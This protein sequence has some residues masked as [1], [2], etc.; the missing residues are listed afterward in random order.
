MPLILDDADCLLWII[1]PSISPFV[2]NKNKRRNILSE[3]ALKNPRSLLN[4]IK[5]RCFYN[6]SLRQEIVDNIK[7]YQSNDTLRLYTFNDK[8][9]GNIEYIDEPFSIDECQQWLSNNL[10]NPRTNEKINI[11]SHVFIELIYTTIQY[12]LPIPPISYTPPISKFE[13]LVYNRMNKIIKDVKFRFE[14]MKEND[15]LFL[16]HDVAS[17]DRKLQVET[18][19]SAA[20]KATNSFDVSSSPV[21]YKSLNMSQKIRLRDKKLENKEEEKLVTEHLY[22]KGFVIKQKKDKKVDKEEDKDVFDNFR[23]F[24]IDLQDEGLNND[25]LINYILEDV[26]DHYKISI[27]E[28]IKKFIT[29]PPPNFIPQSFLVKNH[30]DKIEGV[31]RKF[32]NNICAQL[33][34]PAL[35]FDRYIEISVLSYNNLYK[36]FRNNELIDNVIGELNVFVDRYSSVLDDKVI[37]Y[38]KNLVEDIIPGNLISTVNINVLSRISYNT[39]ISNYQNY[40]YTF[41]CKYNIKEVKHL[42]LRLPEGMGLLIGKPLI[43]AFSNERYFNSNPDY[44]VI[45]EDNRL[46]HF[47]YEECKNWVMIPIINP[48]T[49][50]PILIDTPTYNTLLVISYQYDTNLIPRMITS[51]G[52]KILIALRD[53]IH[54]ILE[55]KGQPPQSREQLENYLIKKKI[56]SDEEFKRANELKELASKYTQ[57][58]NIAGLKWKNVG[59]KKP[60]T[61]IEIIDKKLKAAF[62]KLTDKDGEPPFYVLFSEEDFAK[63]GITDI[64]KDSYI[65]IATYYIPAIDTRKSYTNTVG[66]RWRKINDERYKQGIKRKGV[67]II[68]KKLSKAFSKSI[69][70]D[71]RLPGKVL[72]SMKDF[73]NFGI[74][75]VAKNRYVKLAYYYKPVFAK[76]ANSASRVSSASNSL[77]ATPK[78]NIVRTADYIAKNRYNI[79]NCLKWVMQPNKDPITNELIYT[80]SPE[81]N[82]IFEQALIFDNHIEP[83]DITPKGIKFKNRLLKVQKTLIGISKFKKKTPYDVS[84]AERYE[85]LTKSEICDSINNIHVDDDKDTKYSYFKNKMLKMCDKYLGEKR[86]CNLANIKKKINDK[87]IKG[88]R[89]VVTAFSYYEGSALCSLIVDYDIR[90]K[91]LKLYDNDV[92]NKFINHYKRIF[93]VLIY[94]IVEQYGNLHSIK[95]R[96]VDVG[97]VSREFFTKLFEELFCD[98]ENKKRP[99]IQPEKNNGSNRY[100][101]NPNFEPDENFKTVIKYINKDIKVIGDYNT[102]E[103]YEHIYYIIGKF[104]GITLVNEEIGLPKQFSTYILSRFINPQKTINYYDILYYYLKDFSNSRP[105]MNMMN[106]KQKNNIDYC[107]FNFNDY[108]IISKSLKSNPEG[109]PITKENY[110]KYIL[111]LAK[112]IVTKNFLLKK[113]EGYDKNMKKRYE[114]LFSGFNSELS[115]ILYNNNV[116]IDMLDKLITNEQLDPV[117]LIEFAKKLKI[118]VIKFVGQE[119]IYN[120]NTYPTKTDEEIHSIIKEL[121]IYL[122]NIITIKR[123]GTTDEQHYGFIKK[124]LQFWSGFSHY[125]KLAGVEENGYKFFYLYGGDVRMFPMAHTC[126]YQL[127]FFGF[128]EDKTTAEEKE[129]YLYDKLKFAVFSAGGM[130]IA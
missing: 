123:E 55:E 98:E 95:K 124:L 26:E 100:Y 7:E 120:P 85:I 20:A 22:K 90:N 79:I 10:V 63:F 33:I 44:R 9:A 105:Y 52:C 65:E 37:K 94:E 28:S 110:I 129:T 78:I 73:E 6:S 14:F 13:E 53:A 24:L 81:Y 3:E 127:D 113:V 18:A 86:V 109:H 130:D 76:S 108:Y 96:P 12:G 91:K 62:L 121:R 115:A 116:S 2:N 1:D 112:H 71:S 89:N 97:G 25:E 74:T 49:F 8:I 32:I 107:D 34:D 70:Q 21:S 69:G 40:Y 126:S 48:R 128:P 103:E 59:T 122:T 114:L 29:P 119:D 39:A 93:K 102:G 51:R 99:F 16:T 64:T 60:T 56:I 77:V 31:I 104:L 68:N 88:K 106:E 61:G 5:R 87:F 43:D 92:Q 84:S 45:T 125:N 111:Q 19:A 46:N 15:E 66:L 117:I 118:S 36:T 42:E 67:E 82:E 57:I 80:D 4:K 11:G 47:T 58:P 35:V 30:F 101:I 41:L 50:E 72:F 38:F 23:A 75:D 27:L 17:F 54:K 83:I